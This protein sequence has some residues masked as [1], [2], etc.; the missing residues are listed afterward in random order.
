MSDD[1]LPTTLN[2]HIAATI[3]QEIE[4]LTLS[5]DTLQ[6]LLL[7]V[8]TNDNGSL[9]TAGTDATTVTDREER[10]QPPTR[11]SITLPNQRESTYLGVHDAVGTEIHKG[12][13]VKFLSKGSLPSNTG[14]VYKI[15]GNLRRVTSKDN[16]NRSI[17]RAAVNLQVHIKSPNRVH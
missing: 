2:E 15:S 16:K 13:T 1:G 8:E 5:I 3:R 4:R 17:S 6:E 7:T 10:A 12:D 9:E 14:V 11:R